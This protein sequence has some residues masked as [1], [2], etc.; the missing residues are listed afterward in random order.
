M[1]SASE[2]ARRFLA[3]L[4]GEEESVPRLLQRIAI[5]LEA[6]F[7]LSHREFVARERDRQ[8]TRVYQA[9]VL[10]SQRALEAVQRDM[11]ARQI[12]FLAQTRAQH[13]DQQV[14]QRKILGENPHPSKADV[15]PL[16]A[17]RAVEGDDAGE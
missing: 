2:D 10:T 8:D 13:E 16:R 11:Q 1:E 5:A 7:V 9:E 12:E 14:Y 17:V 4:Q 15:V 6:K 3:E